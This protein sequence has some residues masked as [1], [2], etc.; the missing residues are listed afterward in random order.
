MIHLAF[1]HDLLYAGD[2]AGAAVVD[3]QAIEVLGEALPWPGRT[4]PL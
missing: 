1:R 4:G 2:M 3:R